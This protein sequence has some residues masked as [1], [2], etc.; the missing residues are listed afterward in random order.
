MFYLSQTMQY[1]FLLNDDIYLKVKMYDV[2]L[3]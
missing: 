3:N 2:Q 1:F